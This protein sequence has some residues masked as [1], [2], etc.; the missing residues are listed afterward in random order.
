MRIGFVVVLLCSVIGAMAQT[1][2]KKM[3]VDGRRWE[4][5]NCNYENGI[6]LRYTVVGDT[7]VKGITAKKIQSEDLEAG[8]IAPDYRIVYE[9]NGMTYLWY[10]EGFVPL[11]NFNVDLGESIDLI[12]PNGELRGGLYLLPEDISYYKIENV[13]RKDILLITG[14]TI[15]RLSTN[16]WIEG[17]GCRLKEG[18]ITQFDYESNMD[19]FWGFSAISHC[20]QGDKC[21]Y[22]VQ[23]AG[24]YEKVNDLSSLDGPV[25]ATDGVEDDIV[26]DLMGKRVYDPKPGRIYITSSGKRFFKRD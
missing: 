14:G 25:V 13:V 10:K 11:M 23:Q 20:Y 12:Y 21:L 17:I 24:F 9:K 4:A 7:V 6:R 1:E 8:E 18:F 15:A 2:Y 3:L 16:D 19:R 26:Y 22:D 5:Y